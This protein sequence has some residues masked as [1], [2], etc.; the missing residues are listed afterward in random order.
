M[1]RVCMVWYNLYASQ[2]SFNVCS[3]VP[4]LSAE[5]T[6]CYKRL[7]FSCKCVQQQ[8]FTSLFIYGLFEEPPASRTTRGYP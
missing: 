1:V 4:S 5:V 7:S 3:F 8:M 2:T 6:P